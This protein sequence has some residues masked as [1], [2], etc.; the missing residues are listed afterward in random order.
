MKNGVDGLLVLLTD[1]VSRSLVMLVQIQTTEVEKKG[2]SRDATRE[3]RVL[4]CFRSMPP[5]VASR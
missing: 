4:S 3:L 2:V 1:K 5:A